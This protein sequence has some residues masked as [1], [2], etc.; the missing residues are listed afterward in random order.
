MLR[1]QGPEGPFF[2][3][4]LYRS[5]VIVFW[6]PATSICPIALF[7]LG[8]YIVDP[9]RV[10]IIGADPKYPRLIDLNIQVESL[11]PETP[12]YTSL[13]EVEKELART[14]STDTYKSYSVMLEF[15][16]AKY[17]RGIYA[18]K[19]EADSIYHDPSLPLAAEITERWP[20]YQVLT[21]DDD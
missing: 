11:R 9:T 18:T 7:E 21:G 6:F 12:I 19:D 17:C 1:M 14:M 4:A 3:N 8:R 13:K 2:I 20:H 5:Q 10:L 16:G 15:C